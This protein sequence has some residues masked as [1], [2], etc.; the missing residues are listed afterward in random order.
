[1]IKRIARRWFVVP[2]LVV[3]A[4]VMSSCAGAAMSFE[5]FNRE[6]NGVPATIM[7]YDE[8]GNSM[9]NIHGQSIQVSMDQRF[10]EYST[11]SDGS[12]ITSPGSVLLMTVG[13]HTMSFV[14]STM[15][16]AQDGVSPVADATTKINV[17]NN[18]AGRPWLNRAYE[19]NKN[20]WK[21]K[22][23]TVFIRSQSGKPIAVYAAS[24]VEVFGTSIPKT[25]MLRLDGK[26]LFIYRADYS[27]VDTELLRLSSQ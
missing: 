21:G 18:Q 27:L 26:R 25:T 12:L 9:D 8:D 23:K 7:T 6:W 11:S 3:V 17:S 20:L 16:W 4:L 1:V 24:E 14:G 10:K 2:A 15:L 13:P 19:Y 22:A 5:D